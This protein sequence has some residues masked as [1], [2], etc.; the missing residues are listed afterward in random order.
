MCLPLLRNFEIHGASGPNETTEP[1]GLP[2]E[3]ALRPS[4]PVVHDLNGVTYSLP[5]R[6][7]VAEWI[8][9]MLSLLFDRLH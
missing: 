4:A 3:A 2:A 5:L 9:K 1:A 7:D 8:E 6:N